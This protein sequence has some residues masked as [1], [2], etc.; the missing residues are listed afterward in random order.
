M[1]V[2]AAITAIPAAALCLALLLPT[3]ALAFECS[4]KLNSCSG[5]YPQKICDDFRQAS[6]MNK[7][8]CGVVFQQYKNNCNNNTC[9]KGVKDTYESCMNSAKN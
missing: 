5:I 9:C 7:R 4:A 1:N 6:L 8:Q 2:R 3:A